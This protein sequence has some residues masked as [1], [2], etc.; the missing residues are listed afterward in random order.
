MSMENNAHTIANNTLDPA[1]VVK[2][3]GKL[4][5]RIS[6]RFPQS[7][8]HTVSLHLLKT[9]EKT[10]MNTKLIDRPIYTLRI[11]SSALVLVIVILLVTGIWLLVKEFSEGNLTRASNILMTIEAGSNEIVM[12]SILAFFV[13]G[14]ERS[15]KRRKALTAINE[16]RAIAHVIDMHQLTK[17]PSTHVGI[18]TPTESSPARE[19]DKAGLIRYLDY[20][21]ELLAITGKLAAI[22]IQKFD[23]SVTISAAN[24]IENL[25]TQLSG[26]IWQKLI[27]LY[28]KPDPMIQKDCQ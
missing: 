5:R 11:L 14:I 24:D 7:G 18:Y 13:I 25:T 26:K 21:T 4:S 8:L 9:A 23:D 20:C 15:I 3:V 10:Q 19:L 16:L 2:T 17:D 22:H 28:S 12:A 6:E 1:K 27:I